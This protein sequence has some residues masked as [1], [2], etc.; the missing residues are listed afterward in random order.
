MFY[1]RSK[2]RLHISRETLCVLALILLATLLRFMLIYF[3]WPVT[4]SDEGNMGILARHVAYNGEWPIFFYGLPYLGPLEGYIAAPLFLLFGPSTF[5][6]RLGLLPFFPLFVLCMYYLTRLLYTPKLALFTVLLFCFGSV[7]VIARQLKAVGEYPETLFFA[8]FIS[9]VIS[10]LVLSYHSVSQQVRTTRR[11]VFIYGVLGLVIGVA[12]WVDFLILPFLGTGMLLLLLFCRRELRSWAGFSLLLGIVIGAFPLIYYNVTSPIQDNSLVVLF[13]ID[14]SGSQLHLP[15]LQQIVGTLMISLPNATGFNP[16]CS[17]QSFPFFGT[18][19]ISCIVL[20]GGWTLGY[21]ILW[22]VATL[23]AVHVLWRGRK[24]TAFVNPDWS[25]EKRQSMIRQYCRLMLLVS[26]G[27]T[28]LLYAISP[29]A[30]AFPA[31]TAR[32]LVCVLVALPAILWPL[33]CGLQGW[34]MPTG[35]RTRTSL[36]AR[37]CLLL[38]ILFTFVMGTFTTVT[39][40]PMAQAAY[41]Q[42]NLL[43]QDLLRLGATRIYSEYWTC[44]R[45]IFQ[46]EEQ[47]ICSS[48]DENLNPGF[49]RY[50]PYQS[51][52][53]ADSHPAYVFPQGSQQVA[54]LDARMRND[55]QFS[56]AFRRLTF[57]GYVI[58]MPRT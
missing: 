38:L 17:P 53:Q 56:N 45:L 27:G 51:I 24:G 48:L 3:N 1:R 46:S 6:L 11:R 37:G 5:I 52:V 8:A 36:L 14:R 28:I 26:A 39:Q 23:I 31:P 54:I 50:A 41:R 58:Y 19:D 16:L 13:S 22:A 44:N 20:Q 25:F 4:N 30:A 57:E 40:I 43:V 55:S 9:F 10:W 33:W 12:L 47:I 34:H 7:E 18:P 42:Q 21:L 35:W 29:A 15:F 32:Y 2:K 49:N